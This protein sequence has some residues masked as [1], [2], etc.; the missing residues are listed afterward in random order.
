MDSNTLQDGEIHAP[1]LFWGDGMEK[2]LTINVPYITGEHN[3]YNNIIYGGKSGNTNINVV[4]DYQYCDYLTWYFYDGTT[5]NLTGISW[6][7]Y[8]Y[9]QITMQG[10]NSKLLID[11][12]DRSQLQSGSILV[13]DGGEVE[14][15]GYDNTTVESQSFTFYSGNGKFRFS[16]SKDAKFSD[17]TIVFYGNN[18]SMIVNDF[19]LNSKIENNHFTFDGNYNNFSLIA[20]G[21]CDIFSNTINMNDNDRLNVQ[22]S[23]DGSTMSDNTFDCSSAKFVKILVQNGALL[24][25]NNISCPNN[26]Y[27]DGPSCYIEFENDATSNNNIIDAEKGIPIDL[28]LI[29]NSYSL[30]YNS[31][32][33]S[34]T[35][36]CYGK[37]IQCSI[38]S[39]ATYSNCNCNFPTGSPTYNPT[40]GP[41]SSPSQPPTIAPTSAPTKQVP[42][43]NHQ[44]LLRQ[45]HQVVH[46]VI[47][48]VSHL[49]LFQVIFQVKH[50]VVHLPIIHHNFQPTVQLYHLLVLH[51]CHLL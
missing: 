20:Q 44:Q 4:C 48:Q 5:A 43:L 50:L 21:N 30:T 49:P 42:R 12:N 16:Q 1:G 2:N 26:D 41:T 46:Q 17:N 29:V 9:N 3:F 27:D 40:A 18:N 23:S 39:A 37:T 47:N 13:S 31:Q 32:S 34:D 22:I 51:L 14:I 15:V 10:N 28:K 33:Y 24:N 35:I 45:P 8:S 6:S 38:N 7:Y 25:R 11:L 19:G 36:K